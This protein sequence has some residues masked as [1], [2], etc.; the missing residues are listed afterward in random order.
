MPCVCHYCR[1]GFLAINV[2]KLKHPVLIL[3][4]LFLFALSAAGYFAYQSFFTPEA[5]KRREVAKWV[6]I[7][8]KNAELSRGEKPTLAT[9]TNKEKLGDQ[10]FFQ[11]AENG[12]KI[13]IYPISK[14]AFLYRPSTGKLIEISSDVNI[15]GE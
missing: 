5:L 3:L 15:E 1:L 14:Q 2:M 4:V 10:K 11:K 12:D 13:L 6:E 9:I 8:G 7:I